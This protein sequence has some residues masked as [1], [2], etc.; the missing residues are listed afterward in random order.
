[1][2]GVRYCRVR[3]AALTIIGI[4]AAFFGPPAVAEVAQKGN[5]RI[6]VDARLAPHRLPRSAPAP[7]AVSFSGRIGT[8]DKSGP[9]QLR[10]ISIA[11][12]RQGRLTRRGLPLCRAGKIDPS[13]TSDA[14]MACRPSLVGDGSFAANVKLPQQ[15][16]FPSKGKVL[17]FNGRFRGRPAI[18]AH[19]YGTSPVPT[20]YVL[21]FLIDTRGGTYR[22][23]LEASLPRVTGDWGYVTGIS[24]T[25]DRRF[26]F[27]GRQQ[28]YL[29][30]DCPAP[31]GFP[32]A[33]FPLLQTNFAFVDGKRVTS[34][35]TR[36]CTVR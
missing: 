2:G 9:P 19:I 24:M 8:T 5:L 31:A 17:A 22:T 18:L 32:G 15:S 29:A 3:C 10:T 11:I 27:R 25:L 4:T 28:S 35:L 7:V 33:V 14:L 30:A 16:P 13:T 12:N 21:P 34:T 36:R 26:S 1:M 23:V 6:A 20:S